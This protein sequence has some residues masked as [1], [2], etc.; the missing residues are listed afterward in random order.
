MKRLMIA[1]LVG[2]VL[3]LSPE[4]FAAE[5]KAA[6]LVQ[7]NDAAAS[8]IKGK[9][10]QRFPEF[11]VDIVRKSPYA[12]LYEVI[13]G[14]EVMY[15]SPD[16]EFLIFQGTMLGL[17][18]ERPVNLTQQTKSEIDNL[19]APMRAQELAKLDPK[20]LLTFKASNPKYTINIFTDIDCGYCQKLHRDVPKLN[21]LG[22]TVNYLAFPRSGIPSPGF[23]KLVSVWCAANPQKAMTLAKN[24]EAIEPKTC[25]HGLDKHFELVRK[26]GLG[27]TPAIVLKDGTLLGG[28]VPPEQLLEI[29][30]QH[31][32]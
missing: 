26:F 2:A 17:A 29:L 20:T 11:S 3:M 31:A 12:G 16:A 21:E 32:G 23:D 25:K 28:Y 22:I 9:I 4:L 13:V 8:E 10:Q 19:R 27:G 14:D 1:G 30:K 18:G 24:R 7:A 15:V 6:G 5:K